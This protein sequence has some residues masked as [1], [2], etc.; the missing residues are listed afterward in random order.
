VVR[1]PVTG[2]EHNIHER[3][4]ETLMATITEARTYPVERK[5]AFAYLTDP[6]VWPDFYSGVVEVDDAEHARF[7]KPGDGVD[8]TASLLGRRLRGRATVDEIEDGSL[9]R[10]TIVVPGLPEVHQ[11]WKYEAADGGLILEVT[12]TTDEA[13]SFL[14]KAVDRFVIPQALHRD[15]TR[16]L[17]RLTDIFALGI[18]AA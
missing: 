1:D 18:P 4:E 11:T 5:E 12:L 10:F 14:G 15:I 2:P 8:F 13:T 16:T 7:E 9:V 6:S 3:E 17:D